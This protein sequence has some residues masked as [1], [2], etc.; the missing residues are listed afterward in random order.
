MQ[1]LLL[2]LVLLLVSLVSASSAASYHWP[3]YHYEV[4]WKN[5]TMWSFVKI[6]INEVFWQNSLLLVK[7]KL[8]KGN[9]G[10]TTPGGWMDGYGSY[11]KTQK[12]KYFEIPIISLQV[13]MLV[14]I[15]YV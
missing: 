10:L 14:D 13:N 8:K 2:P 3:P 12:A 4:F 7:G 6:C 11:S 9:Y 5:I 15:L 1:S